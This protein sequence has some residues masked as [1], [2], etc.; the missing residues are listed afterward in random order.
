[1]RQG[2][3]SAGFLQGDEVAVSAGGFGDVDE[4]L[5]VGG[6]G[7]VVLVSGGEEEIGDFVEDAVAAAGG[8]D[9]VGG[10]AD[11]PG[12]VGGCEEECDVA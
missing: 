2:E 12:G 8:E 9:E 3:G 6:E 4:V 11:G 1:M 10:L 5:L 7:L